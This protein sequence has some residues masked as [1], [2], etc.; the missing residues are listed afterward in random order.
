MLTKNDMTALRGLMRE[1]I[2]ETVP[3]MM[4][5]NNEIFG[6]Q[7]KREIRDE[8][9]SFIK[10]SEAGLIR[11]MNAME[12]RLVQQ[13]GSGFESMNE[14]LDDGILP[15]IDSLDHRV[16]HLETLPTH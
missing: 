15:Q 5:E 3:G 7:L 4:R 2:I 6:A 9:H 8:I 12:E 13:M 10:A 16:T 11:R 1:V 14:L